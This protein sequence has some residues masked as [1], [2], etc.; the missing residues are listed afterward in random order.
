MRGG[1]RRTLVK[2]DVAS[3]NA[4]LRSLFLFADFDDAEQV[5]AAG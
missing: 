2:R 1:K 4:P 5:C 3:K